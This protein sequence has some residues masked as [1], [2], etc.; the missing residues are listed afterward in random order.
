MPQ[1][2]VETSPAG[3]IFLPEKE[4]V[5]EI[6]PELADLVDAFFD[7]DWT[8]AENVLQAIADLYPELLEATCSK[9]QTTIML[10]RGPLALHTEPGLVREEI[11]IYLYF[12]A[13]QYRKEPLEN[14]STLDLAS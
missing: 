11:K 2:E 9:L 4:P 7:Q 3:L 1:P 12:L 5:E 14:S 6:K 10:E 13:E 8:M